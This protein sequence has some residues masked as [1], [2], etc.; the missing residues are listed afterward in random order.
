MKPVGSGVAP[1]LRAVQNA[2]EM[3]KL[4]FITTGL[5]PLDYTNSV[6]LGNH[7]GGGGGG[8]ERERKPKHLMH[9]GNI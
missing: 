1:P 3:E 8:I 5:I 2:G 7:W 9:Y 6:S 4:Q